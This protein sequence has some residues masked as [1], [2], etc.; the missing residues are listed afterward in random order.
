[1]TARVVIALVF[2]VSIAGVWGQGRSE[3]E[4][5]SLLVEPAW[6]DENIDHENLVVLDTGR[7]RHDYGA[8]HI[9]GARYF[10]RELYY[11][12]VDGLPGM[13]PGV[14]AVSE[15][16]RQVGVNNDSLVVVYDPGH[17]LWATRLFW[18]LELLGHEHVAVLNGG[19]GA[20]K[21]E[22]LSLA[23]R[24][25]QIT[26]G[27]FTPALQ[28]H[29]VA[30]G[31][32]ILTALG[33]TIVVDARSRPEYDGRD[34]RAERGGHIPGAIHVEWVLNNTNAAVN[35]FLPLD[36]LAE[37][38]EAELEGQDGRIVTHCQTG[39]RGAHTYFV[40][41]LLGYEDV[42]LY[43]ASWV[44]WGNDERFPVETGE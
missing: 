1:M 23:D 42:A 27:E 28:R 3:S 32:E 41:R 26:G 11:R 44:E 20:W 12:K 29:L 17:G 8:G 7:S 18:T 24:P 14:E 19:I 5:P 33:D 38:Y 43:D 21:A 10:G 22:G 39:V 4:L 16:L 2:L 15:S 36:E 40:L 34:V 6:L 25:S 9:P 31:E 13:F 35:T 37:F 30:T